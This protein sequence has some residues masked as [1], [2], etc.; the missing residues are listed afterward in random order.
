VDLNLQIP[1]TRWF[2]ILSIFPNPKK[3]KELKPTLIKMRAL[4]QFFI[5]ETG[6]KE[7]FITSERLVLQKIANPNFP[8]IM[9]TRDVFL[10]LKYFFIPVLLIFLV[11]IVMVILFRR[12]RLDRIDYKTVQMED[13]V[14]N[15]LTE[16]IF[17]DYSEAEIKVCIDTFKTTTLKRNKKKYEF[18]L[19]KLLHIKQNVQQ[20]NQDKFIL[21][22]EHFGFN[23]YTEQLLAD[24]SWERKSQGIM[25]YQILDHK[26]KKELITPFL[27]SNHKALRS[28]ALIAMISLSDENFDV[29]DHYEATLT[30]AEE[31]KILDLIYQ[32]EVSIPTNINSWLQSKNESIV[33]IA[34]KL[35]V[36]YKFKFN[37]DQLIFLLDSP[38]PLVRKEII[39]AIRELKIEFANAILIKHYKKEKNLRNQ[40]SIVKTFQK[41]GNPLTLDYALQLLFN[42]KDLDLKFEIVN[43]IYQIDNNFFSNYTPKNHTEGELIYKMLLHHKSHYIN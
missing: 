14:N 23:K 30:R 2:D 6:I 3:T 36:R 31:F 1:P 34:I 42:E 35:G 43:C 15:F 38:N 17:S 21:I 12:Y 5:A 19:N 11:S 22:Y 37:I 27:Q 28:N 39:I 7:H 41:I 4:L 13:T 10:F 16:L 25:H 20:M 40:I 9:N 32:K 26:A 24:R 33:I 29:L 8:N 18:V